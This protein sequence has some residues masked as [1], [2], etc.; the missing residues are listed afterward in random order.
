MNEQEVALA[1]TYA[2]QAD[3]RVQLTDANIDIWW[4]GLR[5]TDANAVRW[6][7]KQHYATSNAN[8][9]GA[10]VV[11]PAIIRRL[12]TTELNRREQTERALEPP[13][14]KAPNPV[15][16]RKRDPERWDALVR[17]GAED[18]YNELTRRG[19]KVTPPKHMQPSSQ[20][21][22]FTHSQGGES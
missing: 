12:I 10:A 3:P 2:N 8:G 17:Q 11:N 15:S 18:R 20:D 22:G 19:I 1:L 5:A 4:E 21:G 7:I 14:N 6:A 16:F 9:E 13:K